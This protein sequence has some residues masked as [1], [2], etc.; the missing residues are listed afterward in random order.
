[1]LLPFGCACS[2]HICDLPGCAKLDKAHG[3]SY[4]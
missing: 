1:V 4:S 3:A 2:D